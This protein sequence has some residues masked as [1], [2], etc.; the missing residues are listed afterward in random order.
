M[1]ISDLIKQVNSNQEQ[2]NKK[3]SSQDPKTNN[4]GFVLPPVYGADGNGLPFSKINS[5]RSGK[6]KRNIITWFV[7][8][9]GAIKMYIN[10]QGITFSDK[11]IIK[12]NLTKGGYSLQYWGEE[13]TTLNITGTTGSSGIEG[14][15]MLYQIYRAEQYAFDG[16]ALSLA[17]T[18]A[19]DD[20]SNN[21]LNGAGSAIGESIIGSVISSEESAGLLGGILGFDSPSNNLST[22]NIPSLAQY[23]FT[24]EMYYNGE[25]FRGYF[26]DFRV[27]ERAD[28]FNFQYTMNFAVTQRRGMRSN[29][30][31]FH[32]TPNQGYSQYD[33]LNSFNGD[34][35]ER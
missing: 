15:N 22:R 6:I 2:E 11:K 25:T 33:T 18:N 16:V 32:R 14:I 17:A 24:V 20:L 30:L 19:K 34:D 8:E 3:Q 5:N 27:E 10:P 21:L 28:N 29:Y 13:L 35:I 4:D 26:E 12:R 23:A 9:F 31:P 1:A 7:P